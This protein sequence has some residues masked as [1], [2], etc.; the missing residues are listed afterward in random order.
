MNIIARFNKLFGFAHYYK[1]IYEI[2]KVGRVVNIGSAQWYT[3]KHSNVTNHELMRQE[4]IK[5]LEPEQKE[6]I[7][8]D[9]ASIIITGINYL[10]YFKVKK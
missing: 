7:E 4:L 6:L 3:Y 1:L 5:A 9:T 10:G 2:Y 8:L